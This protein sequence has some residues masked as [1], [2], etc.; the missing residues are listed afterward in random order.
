MFHVFREVKKFQY[1]KCLRYTECSRIRFRK[2]LSLVTSISQ[3]EVLVHA[4]WTL[5]SGFERV[6]GGVV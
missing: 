4:H 3:C 1:T 5:R 2:V 6:Y